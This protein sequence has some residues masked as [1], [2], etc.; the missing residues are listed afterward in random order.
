MLFPPL[1][2]NI[3]ADILRLNEFLSLCF[4]S[5]L[6]FLTSFF[7]DF[8]FCCIHSCLCLPPHFSSFRL[9]LFS[10]DSSPL[11]RALIESVGE[12]P[13]LPPGH[14]SLVSRLSLW[15]SGSLLIYNWY[16]GKDGLAMI[17]SIGFDLD[18]LLPVCLR[19]RKTLKRF[20]SRW[21]GK[22]H[23]RRCWAEIKEIKQLFGN[24]LFTKSD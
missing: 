19:R 22:Q 8:S 21:R 20:E 11:W 2:V 6:F 14:L 15:I 10:I 13:S 7:K 5:V 1:S 23:L 9:T 3:S 4:H 17:G 24:C 18:C 16:N 12:A